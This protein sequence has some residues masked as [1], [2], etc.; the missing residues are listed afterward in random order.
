MRLA[1]VALGKRI[2]GVFEEKTK[3]KWRQYIT[4]R[5]NLDERVEVEEQ[6]KKT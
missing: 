6:R 3:R 1:T 5:L 2:R 4:S